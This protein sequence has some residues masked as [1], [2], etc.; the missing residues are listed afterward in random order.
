[1]KDLSAMIDKLRANPEIVASIASTFGLPS[2]GS[3]AGISETASNP[4]LP[5]MLSSI[6]PIISSAVN[7]GDAKHAN[8]PRTNL[9]HALRPYLSPQRQEIVDYIL[10]LS[11]M[12]DLLKKLK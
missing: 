6:A 7:Q 9:L 4:A 11:R 3:T 10:K 8:D 12:G 5:D 1:M 2:P